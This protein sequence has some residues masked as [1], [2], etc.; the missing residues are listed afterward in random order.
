MTTKELKAVTEAIRFITGGY[1]CC[2]HW[3]VEASDKLADAFAEA[4]D[5]FDK[6]QFYRDCGIRRR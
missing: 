3:A 5:N 1:D 2:S 4:D 6:D